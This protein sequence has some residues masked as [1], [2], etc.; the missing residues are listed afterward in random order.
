MEN[1]GLF[2]GEEMGISPSY[3]K[4][5]SESVREKS[6]IYPFIIEPGK[7][8]EPIDYHLKATF[9]EKPVNNDFR[10]QCCIATLNCLRNGQGDTP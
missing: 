7:G 10:K 3:A 8:E 5:D 9:F 4:G 2:K 1:K 6:F